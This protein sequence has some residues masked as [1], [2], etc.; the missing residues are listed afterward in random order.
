MHWHLFPRH[1]GDTAQAGPVWWT[2]KEIM[3]GDDV[4]KDIPRLN[5]LKDA[6]GAA[7]DDVLT[8]RVSEHEMVSFK[9]L[10]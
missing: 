3:Y 9:Q 8:A 7:L 5:R 1:N 2:P 6:L 4:I 10:H